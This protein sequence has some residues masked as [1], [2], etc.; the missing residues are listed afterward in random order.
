MRIT[1]LIQYVLSMT[2][3]A[4]ISA[5]ST[6]STKPMPAPSAPAAKVA[7]ATDQGQS[8]KTTPTSVP[9]VTANGPGVTD[10]VL[11]YPLSLVDNAGY[12]RASQGGPLK[13][14]CEG[15]QVLLKTGEHVFVSRCDTQRLEELGLYADA[16]V[17]FNASEATS[18]RITDSGTYIM[19][20]YEDEKSQALYGF[21]PNHSEAYL[22]LNAKK[23]YIFYRAAG[24]RDQLKELGFLVDALLAANDSVD[25]RF[26]IEISGD[27]LNAAEDKRDGTQLLVGKTSEGR[28][29]GLVVDRN[30][31]FIGTRTQP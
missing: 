29:I 11:S 14:G 2:L 21:T 16:A 18:R 5:C 12:Y 9:T 22:I 31:I 4:V 30:G 26:K 17:G 7:D 28:T 3:I 8:S 24:T 25:A 20:D 10:Q 6:T 27:L 23:E 15:W 13:N 1:R 19:S